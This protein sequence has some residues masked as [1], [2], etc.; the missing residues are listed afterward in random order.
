[1]ELWDG[2]VADWFAQCLAPLKTSTYSTHQMNTNPE[3]TLSFRKQ[4][5]SKAHYGWFHLHVC[6]RHSREFQVFHDEIA[7]LTTR[8]L[9]IQGPLHK[10]GLLDANGSH[11]LIRRPNLLPS[12]SLHP[13]GSHSLSTGTNKAWQKVGILLWM[14]NLSHYWKAFNHPRW[15]RISSIHSM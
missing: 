3:N 7:L 11:S 6:W 10:Q 2:T 15:C 5:P 12:F 1:M 4:K 8:F 9:Y 14:D 13:L